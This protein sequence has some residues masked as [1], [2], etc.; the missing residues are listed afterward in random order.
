MSFNISMFS[1]STDLDDALTLLAQTAMGLPRD[2]SRFTLEQAHE[3][4]CS[5]EGYH[6]LLQTAERFQI[7]PETL[8]GRE[9]LDRL[10][11]DE[12]LSRKAL[13]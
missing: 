3:H 2:S 5:V 8:L 10:F 7:A 6:Q 13:R 12:L 9:Q 4:C 11:R 1:G